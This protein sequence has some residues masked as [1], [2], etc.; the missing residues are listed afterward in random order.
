MPST[1]VAMLPALPLRPADHGINPPATLEG[2]LCWPNPFAAADT[3][4]ESKV[5]VACWRR[6]AAVCL[7]GRRLA[8]VAFHSL[9]LC[10]R[11]C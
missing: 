1:A 2:K 7:L 10:C 11:R 9:F 8:Q 6:Q 5:L 3:P 4:K